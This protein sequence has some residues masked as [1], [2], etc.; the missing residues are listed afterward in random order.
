MYSQGLFGPTPG[1]YIPMEPRTFPMGSKHGSQQVD[2]RTM[3]TNMRSNSVDTEQSAKQAIATI[4]V[5]NAN[6]MYVY[7]LST[8][9]SIG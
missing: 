8:Y 7:D 9:R 4:H 1:P 3:K 2:D 6:L 5:E